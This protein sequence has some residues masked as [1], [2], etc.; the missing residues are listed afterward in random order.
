VRDMAKRKKLKPAGHSATI[1][2]MVQPAIVIASTLMSSIAAYVLA[3]DELKAILSG[4]G[5]PVDWFIV[6]L[7]AG[8][9]FLIDMAIIVSAT[10]YKMHAIRRDPRERGWK[11]LSVIVLGLGLTSESMTLLYFFVSSAPG[12]FPGWLSSLAES[13]HSALAI[14]RAFMPPVIVAYFVAGILPVVIERSDR[15]REIKSRTSQDI[16]TLVDRLAEVEETDDKTEMLKALGGLL[17]LNTYASYDTDEQLSEDEQVARD[18]K[19][20]AR[21]AHLHGLNWQ[22]LQVSVAPAAPAPLALEA[23]AE[24]TPGAEAAPVYIDQRSKR[25]KLVGAAPG[26]RGEG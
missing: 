18:N 14:S 11:R 3:S 22:S 19:L 7:C 10:R 15:N 20:L 12:A 5:R 9:G 17:A 21:L 16:A 25:R 6:V 24:E 4:Q 8:M 13:V 2:A 23:P 26:V 1:E